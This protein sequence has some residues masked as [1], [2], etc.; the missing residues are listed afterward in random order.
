MDK[1][2]TPVGAEG[3]T[4]HEGPTTDY[5]VSDKPAIATEK[6]PHFIPS[7]NEPPPAS[8]SEGRSTLVSE[9]KPSSSPTS[10]QPSLSNPNEKYPPTNDGLHPAGKAGKEINLSEVDEKKHLSITDSEK[11]YLST[12]ADSGPSQ[13]DER[14]KI[15]VTEEE[16]VALTKDLKQPTAVAEEHPS[17]ASEGMHSPVQHPEALGAEKLLEKS[18]AGEPTSQGQHAVTTKE[19]PPSVEEKGHLTT[20]NT[21]EPTSTTVTKENIPTGVKS[22]PSAH[23]VGGESPRT[24][25]PNEPL[26]TETEYPVATEDLKQHSSIAEKQAPVTVTEVKKSPAEE[27]FTT[28]EAKKLP[29]VPAVEEHTHVEAGKESLPPIV[30]KEPLLPIAPNESTSTTAVEAPVIEKGEVTGLST[31]EH[32]VSGEHTSPL[33]PPAEVTK[34]MEEARPAWE[35]W[36]T[37]PAGNVLVA[38]A[39]T[40]IAAKVGGEVARLLRLPRIVGK[41]LMG[42]LL[43]NIYFLTGWDFF[44]FLRVM[45]FLKMVSYFGALTLLLSVGI[46]TDLRSVVRVGASA[47]L[48]ALGSLIGP[49]GL[50][51]LVSY[52]LLPDT[53]LSSKL[54]LSIILCCTSTG[55]IAATLSELKAIN[56]LEGRILLGGAIITDIMVFLVF[57]IVSGIVVKGEAPILGVM[58]TVGIVFSFL[59]AILV[60]SLRYGERVGDFATRK[61][62]EGIKISILA[63]VCL[64]LAF[65]STSIGL[66]AVIGA[67]AAGLLLR[68]MRLKDSDGRE[69]SIEWVIRP[70][71]MLLVPI[72]FI[73]VG[74]LVKWESFLDKDAML[75]GIAIIGAAV[76]GKMFAGVCP[77]EKGVN[78]LAIGLGIAPKLE[79]TLV[80]AGISKEL[81]IL[82]D[83]V[84]SSIIVVIMFTSTICISLFKLT[85]S[86]TLSTRNISVPESLHVY[87]KKKETRKVLARLKRLGRR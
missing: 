43:G 13:V 25:A 60:A 23:D 49:A 11:E 81:G 69:Y 24:V 66:H 4:D 3:R 9:E 64:L 32:S 65:L 34:G 84:F 7:E 54:I 8:K 33:S 50:G 45:P 26:T 47:A 2:F 86:R 68:H 51:F 77:I 80:L 74:A 53:P 35:I 22:E 61:V 12:K 58:I 56:T 18:T 63:I 41:L 82:N 17:T 76:S 85:L 39:I 75:V 72:L 14:Q 10:E 44:N 62:P 46:H 27:H 78:R 38:V 16:N 42:M 70:A 79:N 6:E 20:I 30:D 28:L 19:A 55:L 29:E 73:R 5:F 83:A 48:V 36:H 59:A 57:G 15:V 52:F 87:H 40:L 37:D 21:Q 67:F 31:S 1:H 71:Y